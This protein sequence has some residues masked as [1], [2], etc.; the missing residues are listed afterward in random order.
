MKLVVADH[1][2]TKE[3]LLSCDGA[4]IRLAV[5]RGLQA[6]DKVV[7]SFEGVTDVT[8]VF[9]NTAIGRFYGNYSWDFL[10]DNLSVENMK[11]EDMALL[12][13]VVDNA[14]CFFRKRG[15]PFAQ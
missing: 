3:C 15:S 12:K 5:K 13:R 4:A 9:L 1:L 2:K 7:L 10:K 11:P 6:D 8:S 14:K